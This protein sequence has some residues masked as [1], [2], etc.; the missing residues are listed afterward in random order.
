LQKQHGTSVLLISHDLSVVAQMAD[1]IAV[2]YSGKI[3]EQASAKDLLL[4]PL[5]P[6]TKGLLSAVVRMDDAAQRF[7]QIPGTLPN[8]AD[9]PAGCYFSP[10]CTAKMQQCETQ[11]PCLCDVGDGHLVRCFSAG[12]E[13]IG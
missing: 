9:K 4:H 8:P 3:A 2:M 5:H 6:Y 7:M 1:R 10:R 12:G 13:D 11:M